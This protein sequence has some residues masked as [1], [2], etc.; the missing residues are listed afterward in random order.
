MIVVSD[1]HLKYKKEPYSSSQEKFLNWLNENYYNDPMIF[2]GDVFDASPHMKTYH[3]FQ[4]FLLNRNGKTFILNGNHDSSKVKGS[5]VL[6]F[7]FENVYT[8]LSEDVVEIDGMKCLMLPYKYN[9][10][11]YEELEGEYDYIFTH[12]TPTQVQFSNEGINFFKLKGTFI[13]GHTHIP[14]EFTDIVGN[15]HYVLGVPIPTRHLEDVNHKI[16]N[17][18]KEGIEFIEAPF[19]FKYETIQY[20]EFPENKT[21][22]YNIIDAPSRKMVYEKY[23]DYHIR[24]SGIK[25]LRNEMTSEVVQK[26]FEGGSILDKFKIFAKERGLSEE[27]SR[28]CSERLQQII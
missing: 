27:V 9:Y 20:G 24:K 11:E 6:A 22:M 16:V 2:L 23:K 28:C 19:Y 3:L 26:E 7:D 4:N 5:S 18:T 15:K 12:V 8:Y 10:K 25:L 17:I 14:T 21:N 13:H 1:L